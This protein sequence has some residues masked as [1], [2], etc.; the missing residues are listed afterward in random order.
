[1]QAWVEAGVR[2]GR[3]QKWPRQQKKSEAGYSHQLQRVFP[4]NS[5]LSQ[6]TSSSRLYFQRRPPDNSSCI[7]SNFWNSVVGLASQA[8]VSATVLL[9]D[10]LATL[11]AIACSVYPLTLEVQFQSRLKKQISICGVTHSQLNELSLFKPKS[12]ALTHC[13]DNSSPLLSL[14]ETPFFFTYT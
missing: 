12:S 5:Q 14:S 6:P 3:K 4:A 10:A 7:S 2:C 1:M 11:T 9:A 13:L 8:W